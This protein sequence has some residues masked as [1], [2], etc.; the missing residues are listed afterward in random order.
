MFRHLP[1]LLFNYT[2]DSVRY[3]PDFND[4][5]LWV[6]L[7]VL[8]VVDTR[9]NIEYPPTCHLNPESA[10]FCA[11]KNS[12]WL[13]LVAKVVTVELTPKTKCK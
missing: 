8:R 7:H 5:E 12:W 6:M 3:A 4:K 13:S 11:T 9:I 1:F 10:S 2:I